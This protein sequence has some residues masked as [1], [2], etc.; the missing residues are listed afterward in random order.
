VPLLKDGLHRVLNLHYQ[1]P[2][3]TSS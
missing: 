3:P 2:P 1:A